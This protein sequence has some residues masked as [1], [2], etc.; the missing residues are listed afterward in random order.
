MK[1]TFQI[2]SIVLTFAAA[3]PPASSQTYRYDAA[4]RLTQ[5]TY[6]SGTTIV[7]GWDGQGNLTSRV[8]TA[9][10]PAAGGGGGGGGCFIATA[11][12]GSI[13]HP[14]VAALRAFRDVHL[15]TNPFGTAFVE[16][17]YATSPP[18]ADVIAEHEAL[19]TLTRIALTPLVVT[20]V[21]PRWALVVW[22]FALVV[23]VRY[24]RRRASGLGELHSV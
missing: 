4:G 14:H 15:L 2:L 3:A 19:R 5:V 21:Y 16:L 1:T 10:P 12:Y 7:Y 17:Y 6:A 22:T 13:L 11:A 23:V 20:V 8:T 18:L 9:Q 24:R